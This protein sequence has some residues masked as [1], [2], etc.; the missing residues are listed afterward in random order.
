M[1]SGRGDACPNSQA[2]EWYQREQ[3]S[4]AA[5][6]K[7]PAVMDEPTHPG[8]KYRIVVHG[9][10]GDLLSAAFADVAVSR[11]SGDTVLVAEVPDQQGLYGLIDR[12]RD[13][14]VD[15]VTLSRTD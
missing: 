10:F 3:G 5:L 1:S 13:H 11:R 4:A 2:A 7:A 9:E 6:R 8:I 15:L 14:G 12:L